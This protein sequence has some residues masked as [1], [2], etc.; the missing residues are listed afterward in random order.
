MMFNE[1][2][3]RTKREGVIIAADFGRANDR[4]VITMIERYSQIGG[5]THP[6]DEYRVVFNYVINM[7]RVFER[8]PY[9]AIVRTIATFF[10]NHR[11]KANG[12]LVVDA[13]G[14]GTALVD[15]LDEKDLN[16]ISVT[17][18]GGQQLVAHDYFHYSVPKQELVTNFV[19]CLQSAILKIAEGT[20][21]AELL[22]EELNNFGYMVNKKSG[23]ASYGNMTEDV[24]D[25]AV[26]SAAIGMWYAKYAERYMSTYQDEGK[27]TKSEQEVLNYDPLHRE[28]VNRG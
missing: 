22:L 3:I 28:D 23:T 15:M 26:M 4:T 9:P 14:V 19:V 21:N 13:T 24:H 16:P 5:L 8:T 27:Q 2:K 12:S 18:T 10:D 7:I 20:K 1:N 25:D 11:I 6:N 17:I